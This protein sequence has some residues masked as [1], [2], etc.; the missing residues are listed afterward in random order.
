MPNIKTLN[1]NVRDL[2]NIHTMY[3]TDETDDRKADFFFIFFF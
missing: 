3:R 2:T 1:Q